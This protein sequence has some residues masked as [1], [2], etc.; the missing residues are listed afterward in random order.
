[1]IL[2]NIVNV[3]WE[4]FHLCRRTENCRRRPSGAA[5]RFGDVQSRPHSLIRRLDIQLTPYLIPMFVTH[6]DTVN[7]LPAAPWE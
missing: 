7:E 5:Q 6:D 4:L 1:M 3:G 2:N